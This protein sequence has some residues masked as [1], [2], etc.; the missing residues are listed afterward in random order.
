MRKILR[1]FL[2]LVF[3]ASMLANIC[4]ADVIGPSYP[5]MLLESISP[6]I[7]VLV[8]LILI[9][10]VAYGIFKITKE[11]GEEKIDTENKE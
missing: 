9:A 2:S 10:G 8:A 3:L 5:E 1:V 6:F 11:Q 7:W 4:Y